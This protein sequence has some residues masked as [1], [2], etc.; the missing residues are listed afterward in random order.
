MTPANLTYA[1]EADGYAG[2]V[3]AVELRHLFG[4]ANYHVKSADWKEEQPPP[5]HG[6]QRL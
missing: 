4:R 6:V 5:A 2:R 1:V 3:W